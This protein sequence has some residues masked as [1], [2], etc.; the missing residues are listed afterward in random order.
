MRW[1]I[2]LQNKAGPNRMFLHRWSSSFGVNKSTWGGLLLLALAMGG[3]IIQFN[4]LGIA[5]MVDARLDNSSLWSQVLSSKS[6][7]DERLHETPSK[8][9][10]ETCPAR[11]ETFRIKLVED[12]ESEHCC[13]RCSMHSCSASKIH[14]T[15]LVGPACPVPPSSHWIIHKQRPKRYEH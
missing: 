5:V 12:I 14:Y 10:P 8:Y 11:R 3:S 15:V 4:I 1:I 9:F 6:Q 2:C 13:A 7:N